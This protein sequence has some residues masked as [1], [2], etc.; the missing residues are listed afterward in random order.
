MKRCAWA[1]GAVAALAVASSATAADKIRI[2]VTK[3][4]ASQRRGP[5]QQLPDQM[6]RSQS[7]DVYYEIELQRMAADAPEAAE[8][9]YIVFVEGVMGRIMLGARGVE[10][11]VL[12]LGQAVKVETKAI[13]L[14]GVQFGGRGGMEQ[15]IYG[16]AIRVR[17]ATSTIVAE[18]YS[19]I[20]MQKR[21]DDLLIQAQKEPREEDVPVPPFP[22]GGGPD[23]PF[24]P[25]RRW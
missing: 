13:S 5:V 25:R 15:S 20:D 23:R 10:A 7:S 1:I 16:Y 11:A 8:V 2:A 17:D 9:E 24:P 14:Q 21:V 6:A 22:P 19:S 18:K 3:K 12:P 4:T